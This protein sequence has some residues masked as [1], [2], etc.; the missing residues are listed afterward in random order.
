MK[1]LPVKHDKKAS[2]DCLSSMIRKPVKGLPVKN[3]KKTSGDC[4]SS[5]IRQPALSL[6]VNVQMHLPVNRKIEEMGLPLNQDKKAS[7]RIPS[8]T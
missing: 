7:D 2:G 3:D 6:L 5:M 4:L 1:G 8:L